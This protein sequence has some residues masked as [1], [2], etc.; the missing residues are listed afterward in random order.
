MHV[1]FL[2]GREIGY[3]RNQVLHNAFSRFAHVDTV[4]AVHKPQSLLANSL[5][6]AAQATPLLLRNRYDLVFVGFYGHLILRMIG[7]LVRSPLLFDAFISTYDTL[8]FDRA[9]Y[10][11]DSPMGRAAFA[12]DSS[13]LRRADH[14]LLD[15]QSHIDYFVETFGITHE[16]FS[17]VPVGCSDDVYQ[18]APITQNSTQQQKK[19]L[20]ILYYSTF[21]PL[22]GIDVIL[23]AA[24]QLNGEPLHFRLI[25]DG[26][27]FGQMQALAAELALSN[28]TFEPPISQ[29]E[30]ASAI[31]RAD[32]C[33]GGHFYAGGKAG[34]VI[35]GKIYQMLAVGRPVIA[36]DAPGNRELLTHGE[37]AYLIPPA[38]PNA[39]A[40]AI[41][42]LAAEPAYREKL[43]RAGRLHYTN[44]CNEERITARL[45]AI[46][47]ALTANG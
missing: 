1:L 29:T 12:L 18:P 30:V 32:I 8:C 6:I 20:D 35:P 25:G 10:A 15:T 5:S 21:L 11:P 45:H 39:L 44:Y 47:T 16:G 9:L 23:Q 34:R 33:L 24:A 14:V 46:V 40:G 17:A 2:V 42:T 22:H 41:R 36:A 13:A 27:A 7:P 31:A 3:A 26:P 38:D 43:A 4:A 37:N 19:A 28:V